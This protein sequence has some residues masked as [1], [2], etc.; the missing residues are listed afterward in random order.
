MTRL[1]SEQRLNL[2]NIYEGHCTF[3]GREVKYEDMVA[4]NITGYHLPSCK[5]CYNSSY[6][7][8]LDS[9]RSKIEQTI[10][11]FYNSRVGTLLYC[12]SGL[13]TTL[14][15]NVIFH[16]EKEECKP[17]LHYLSIRE[18][19]EMISRNITQQEIKDLYRKP[20]WCDS[21]NDCSKW[22]SLKI[23][24]QTDCK[25]CNFKK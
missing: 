19:M 25:N 2:Y 21:E 18:R 12:Y 24:E 9:F 8:D 1:T 4:C 22:L 15:K 7:H 17:Y 11:H 13:N 23:Y 16:F 6:R 3:C 5:T 20:T 10:K 14:S